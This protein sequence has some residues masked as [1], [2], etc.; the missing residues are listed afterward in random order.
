ME[1]LNVNY[2]KIVGSGAVSGSISQIRGFGSVPKF[3]ES[4]TLL[5]GIRI[6]ASEI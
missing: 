1:V 2:K 3:H 4:A 5:V 6:L